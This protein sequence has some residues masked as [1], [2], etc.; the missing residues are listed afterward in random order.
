MGA[1]TSVILPDEPGTQCAIATSLPFARHHQRHSV[2]VQK[3][4]Q[5]DWDGVLTRIQSHP[6]EVSQ[7]I[8]SLEIY[9]ATRKRV[10]PLHLVCACRPP[11]EVVEAMVKVNRGAC[12][13]V[14]MKNEESRPKKQ[15]WARKVVEAAAA[16]ATSSSSSTDGGILSDTSSKGS[17]THN[18]SNNTSGTSRWKS[19]SALIVQSRR[20]MSRENRHH[21]SD[22]AFQYQRSSRSRVSLSKMLRTP[23]S[24]RNHPDANDDPGFEQFGGYSSGEMTTSLLESQQQEEKCEGMF[25]ESI[26][27]FAPLSEIAEIAEAHSDE[28]QDDNDDEDRYRSYMPYSQPL[29]DVVLDGSIKSQGSSNCTPPPPPLVAATEQKVSPRNRR[30]HLQRR[31]SERSFQGDNATVDPSSS[32]WLPLHVAVVFRASPAIVEILLRAYPCA[33]K[34]MNGLGMLALH[35][36]CAN[37]TEPP[38]PVLPCPYENSPN[39]NWKANDVVHLLLQAFPE[40][41]FMTSSNLDGMTPKQYAKDNFS[42][43]SSGRR[44]ILSSL[45]RSPSHFEPLVTKASTQRNKQPNVHSIRST[46]APEASNKKKQTKLRSGTSTKLWSYISNKS[47][48]HALLRISR[49]PDEA[50]VWTMMDDEHSSTGDSC[51]RLPLHRACVLKAPKS[52]VKSL[53]EAYPSGASSPEKFAMLP[54]HNAAAFHADAGV[55]DILLKAYP[56]GSQHRDAWGRL[57]LHVACVAGTSMNALNLLL[58]AHPTAVEQ[59]DNWGRTPIDCAKQSQHPSKN[60]ILPALLTHKRNMDRNDGRNDDMQSTVNRIFHSGSRDPMADHTSVG[61]GSPGDTRHHQ[62][63][64]GRGD[65]RQRQR[66]SLGEGSG[67]KSGGK[68]SLKQKSP[69]NVREMVHSPGH[70]EKAFG[71]PSPGA[72]D[73]LMSPTSR[74]LYQQQR[75]YA[76]R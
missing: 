15:M 20:L 29:N 6:R 72:Y 30:G 58:E 21:Q 35:L 12:A 63:S 26:N 10:T 71:I 16:A 27:S 51:Y 46:D 76:S 48:R 8:K 54:V 2:L 22:S 74:N 13:S 38:P 60:V 33:A 75:Q 62:T 11:P 49:A 19:D 73:E 23:G 31:I 32:H 45:A 42:K 41:M 50:A 55:L 7:E 59:Q 70:G 24:R 53:V 5:Y 39:P 9:D 43:S 25:G 68:M 28:E 44:E 17:S 66:S 47:W 64:P 57:P 69:R 18:Q 37:M 61:M 67:K 40:A 65:H 4:M 56:A 14:F 34:F 52:I 3:I 36:V 1:G